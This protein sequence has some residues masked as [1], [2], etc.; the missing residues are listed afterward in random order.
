MTDN[1]LDKEKLLALL[2]PESAKIDQTMEKELAVINNPLL[3]EVI[4]Y[5]LFNGGKRFRPILTV[6]CARLCVIDKIPEGFATEEEL[7]AP[8]NLYRLATVFEYLHA[9]SLLHDDVIDNAKT[10][11]GKEAANV[12]FGVT[13][14]I[15]AGDFLHSLAMTLAGE[16]AGTGL[17]A[18]VG[19]AI[20]AMIEAEFLQM[21]TA[22]DKFLSEENYFD[23]LRGKTGA[24]IATACLSGGVYEQGADEEQLTALNLYGNGLGLAFQVVDDLL[25]YLGDSSKTGKAVGND[26]VEGKMTL[27]LIHALNE[28]PEKEKNVLLDLL[29]RPPEERAAHIDQARAF[30]EKYQGFSYSRDMAQTLVETAVEALDIFPDSQA[31]DILM[32][33]S[34]YVLTRKK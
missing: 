14:V 4:N 24:L 27:P 29:A 10:R 1:Q 23:I 16:I 30:I 28:A 8:E 34:Q 3:S 12:K 7:V 9:A 13:P 22:A 15:L 31:K 18:A 20:C 17:Q 2:Q 11:R 21:Q 32:A 25:D 19:Q 6:L 26:F 33:L 5:A